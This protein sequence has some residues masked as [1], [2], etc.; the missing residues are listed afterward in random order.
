MRNLFL[1]VGFLCI[2]NFL[3][4]QDTAPR[5]SIIVESNFIAF[6]SVTY[7]R[8]IPIKEK[9]AV[10]LEGGYIMGTGFGYGSH[11]LKVETSLLSFGPR[12]FLETGV[13]FVY[14]IN[15]D[16][17]PGLK[18]AYRFQGSNGITL[19]VAA[20][21]LFNLDPVFMPTIGIGYSF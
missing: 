2:V 4:A 21:I 5:N 17:S 10:L 20:N 14:G 18:I 6:S 12:N 3:N 9:V 16:S 7:D 19:R 1:V 8:I 13:Q 15:D 11:W